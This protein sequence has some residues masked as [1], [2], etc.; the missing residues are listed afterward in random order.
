MIR[1]EHGWERIYLA[2]N[3]N[4]LISGNRSVTEAKGRRHYHN[5]AFVACWLFT[6][7][8]KKEGEGEKGAYL[9]TKRF[10]QLVKEER[11]RK[12]HSLPHLSQKK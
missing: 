2:S 12:L 3:S 7:K 9:F 8:T 1:E 11:K 5:K 10:K 6:S 4:V